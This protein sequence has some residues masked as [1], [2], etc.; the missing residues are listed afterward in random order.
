L[1]FSESTVEDRMWLARELE[2]LPDTWASLAGGAI[3]PGQVREIVNA[4]SMVEEP[5][6]K[7][8]IEA[9]VLP[10]A[11]RMTR[12]DTRRCAQKALLRVDPEG[13]AERA[14]QARN[15]RRAGFRPI[16]DGQAQLWLTGPA[17]DILLIFTALTVG[18]LDLQATGQVDTLGQGRV[19]TAR[20][21]AVAFLRSRWLPGRDPLPVSVGLIGKPSTFAGADD[22]PVELVG[23]GPITADV[24]RDL[25]AGRRPRPGPFPSSAEQ[26]TE[27]R[28]LR[29]N[30]RD[31]HDD[32]PPPEDWDPPPPPDVGP[33][34]A[35]PAGAPPETSPAPEPFMSWRLIP[36]DS[37]TG[38][39]V[40]PPGV[41]VDAHP[42]R[43]CA[44]GVLADTGRLRYRVC[45]F[46]GC[47]MPAHRCDV[48]HWITV[49]HGGKTVLVNLGLCC[50]HH[51]RTVR[52]EAGWTITPHDDGTGTL[53]TPHGREYLVEPYDYLS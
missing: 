13:A 31:D 18:A 11:P 21:W 49:N 41:D 9:R 32:D 27:L 50:P 40:P 25:A 2:C 37:A 23:Y 28:D 22:D 24:A 1:R 44:T 19:D 4:T 8:A 26:A 39:V 43:R 36:V 20:D 3:T 17:A 33:G 5:E 29:W 6:R 38:W 16:E 48:D 42:E 53:T 47:A 12:P 46:P 30:E 15:K 51:N 35:P 52:N 34:P 10:K 45:A 7:A 14:E